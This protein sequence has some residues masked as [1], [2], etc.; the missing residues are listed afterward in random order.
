[1]SYY[2]NQMKQAEFFHH[3]N[4]QAISCSTLQCFLVQIQVQKPNPHVPKYQMPG[5]IT[6]LK[7]SIIRINS[8]ITDNIRKAINV[9]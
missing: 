7:S 4:Q 8:N 6:T 3:W 9:E 2:T 5:L 1:M